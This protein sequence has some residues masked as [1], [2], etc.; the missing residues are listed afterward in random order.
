MVY[1][2]IITQG[3][4]NMLR[5]IIA[6][7]LL[8]VFLFTFIACTDNKEIGN[9]DVST[10]KPLPTLTVVSSKP[11]KAYSGK[12]D[13]KEIA[14]PSLN[15]NIIAEPK[16]QE[17]NVY[18]PQSYDDGKKNYPVV[19]FLPGFGD[20]CSQYGII[21]KEE[22]DK[23]IAEDKVKEM[24]I[25]AVNGRNVMGGSFYVNSPVTG[26]WEDF[27][28]K[29]VVN[30]IDSNY[31]TIENPASRG[32]CGHSMG[33]FGT[34]NI[35]MKHPDV[36]SMAYSMSPGLFDKDGLSESPMEWSEDYLTRIEDA[37]K[38]GQYI[39]DFTNAYGAAFAPDDKGK[40]PYIKY[41]Y[42]MV[43]KKLVRDD[44]LWKVWDSGFGGFDEKISKYKEN[45]LKLKGLTIDFGENDEYGWIQK[46]CRVNL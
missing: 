41:P 38:T 6:F 24:I 29:D 17:I 39:G 11:P 18:L 21:F 2:N 32:I 12:I 3:G 20:S 28:V 31:R 25:V 16:L 33:G 45:L 37:Q 44:A 22:M 26:N 34:I 5:K 36:F 1:E 10:K 13:V 35:A 42:K 7:N 23:L 8:V 15:N 27:V 14:A 19:Y 40:A 30:Y 4:K 43:N 9:K 46:G